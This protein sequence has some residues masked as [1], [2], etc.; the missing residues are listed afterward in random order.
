VGVIGNR[1]KGRDSLWL[2]RA[3]P[4]LDRQVVEADGVSVNAELVSWPR[5]GVKGLGP[6]GSRRAAGL[7][8]GYRRPVHRQIGVG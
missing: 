3:Y 1:M 6:D 8:R 7:A 5:P 4:A 2:R